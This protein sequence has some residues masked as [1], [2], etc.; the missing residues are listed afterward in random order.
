MRRF[1]SEK[2]A[3][4]FLERVGFTLEKG[5]IHNPKGKIDSDISPLQADAIDYLC[6]E[7]DYSTP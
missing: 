1:V 5:V 3:I 7:W 6:Q 2:S 4:E